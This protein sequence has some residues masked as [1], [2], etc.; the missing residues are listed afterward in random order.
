MKRWRCTED[1]D[2]G[3]HEEGDEGV[4]EEGD[5]GMQRSAGGGKGWYKELR[6][7][8]GIYR[9]WVYTIYNITVCVE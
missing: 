8:G 4:Q 7:G 6:R 5:E 1:G 2:E 9:S 3:V